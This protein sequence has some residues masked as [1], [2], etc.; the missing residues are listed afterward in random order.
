MRTFLIIG[1][2]L[3]G[4]TIAYG[5]ETDDAPTTHMVQIIQ[6]SYNKGCEL[7]EN[8]YLPSQIFIKSGDTVTWINNDD[9]SHTVTSGSPTDGP[10]KIFD[11][12]LM[13][14][15]NLFSYTFDEDKKSYS[16]YCIIHPWMIGYVVVGNTQ[17]QK[18]MTSD[19]VTTPIIFDTDFKIETF[20]SGL[21]VPTTM[22][23][24]EDD[25]LVLQKNDGRVR[26]IRDGVLQDNPA[27]DLEVSNY[28]EQGLLGIT[29][30]KNQVYL[31]LSESHHDGGLSLGNRIYKY[32][33]DGQ[34]LSNPHLVRTLP[35]W[36]TAY[37]SGV[38]TS[39]SKG[40]IYA[41][42]G[43]HYKFGTL[44]NFQK[45][46][47]FSC[48]TDKSVCDPSDKITLWNSLRETLSCIKVSFQYY[49]TN[50][51][52]WQ[53]EQ[54]DM[55]NNPLEENPTHILENIQSCI[56]EFSFDSFSDGNWRDTSVVLDIGSDNYRAIGIRNSFGITID[57]L[58]DNLWMTENGPEKFDEINLVT[59]KF[60][61]GWAKYIG[62]VDEKNY[63][64]ALGY[65]EYLY[66]NPE[67]HWEL[68]IGITALSFVNSSQFVKYKDWLFVG[69]SNN[70]NIYK[71]KLNAERTGF[72]LQTPY[73]R[74]LV[75]NIDPENK[76]GYFHEPMDEILLGTNFG[77]ISD[78]KFGPD[79]SMYV[80]S[81][82]SG[83][84]YKI[85]SK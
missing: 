36:T 73:L 13:K 18:I 68:P 43:S 51:Y 52:G 5:Q 56:N 26:L 65:E 11:S 45:F 29:S 82:M 75:V 79:G 44:Q 42:S 53:S 32:D 34:Q 16:Y 62:I 19:E 59:K 1:I 22:T 67:F 10:D 60:N 70:G 23:F 41:V 28:G 6:N 17:L 50:P 7:E 72:E 25:I 83:T 74:D 64:T 84:I 12:G 33:W 54:P 76:S 85:T 40:N 4:V 55:S 37:N 80:V 78:L 81:L 57:P 24:V 47:S 63:P 39:D 61:S 20:V 31:F 9:A 35:G 77:I 46:E 21:S 49:T 3:V 58:T 2:V 27:L 66:S 15:S 8:C 71:F 38:M 30:M 69:D 48:Y 14:K